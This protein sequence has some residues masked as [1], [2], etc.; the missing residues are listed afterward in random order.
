[1]AAGTHGSSKQIDGTVE[2]RL[3]VAMP[4]MPDPRFAQSVIYMCAHNESGA[5]GLV[6][7][8][9]IDNLTIPELLAHLG[10]ETGVHD[11]QEPVHFGGPV[12]TGRG[13]VLH[14][15]E[16]VDDNTWMVGDDFAVTA[17]L[18]ILKD[19]AEGVGPRQSL[20]ALGYAGWGPGQL[21]M[22]IQ[23]NGWLVVDADEELVFSDDEDGKWLRAIRKLGIDP[24]LL[25][26]EGG[27]A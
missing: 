15:P 18:D 3:L 23:A 2:G 19:M 20:L 26:R 25:S 12:E 4:H 5:M 24:A 10:I 14:S 13:F 8:R 27:H 22:E 11:Q 9:P 7:N 21:D 6:I 1:M 17:T 16:Y